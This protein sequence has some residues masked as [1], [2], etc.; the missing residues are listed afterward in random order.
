MT[1]KEL[2]S[3][4]GNDFYIKHDTPRKMASFLRAISGAI[5][6]E[7]KLAPIEVDFRK[8]FPNYYGNYIIKSQK[9]VLNS[10]LYNEFEEFKSSKNMYYIFEMLESIVHET[11]HHIQFHAGKSIHPIVKNFAELALIKDGAKFLYNDSYHLVPIEI[12]AR[13]Y[14]FLRLSESDYLKKYLLSQ[15]YIDTEYSNRDKQYD[16]EHILKSKNQYFLPVIEKIKKSLKPLKLEG[17]NVEEQNMAVY[18]EIAPKFN[19]GD[20]TTLSEKEQKRISTE[21]NEFC[22]RQYRNIVDFNYKTLMESDEIDDEIEV[23][24]FI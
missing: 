5:C 17:K 20:T 19:F 11:R 22:D 6:S 8:S 23:E 16:Y 13:H 1:S 3:S 12:D 7:Y 9:I 4:V 2:I 18:Y 10:Y 24:V 15:D 14:A 21:S